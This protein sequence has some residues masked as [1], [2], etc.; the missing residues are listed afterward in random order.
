M[1]Q[2]VITKAILPK[3]DICLTTGGTV[4]YDSPPKPGTG[5]SWGNYCNSCISYYGVRNSPITTK[6]VKLKK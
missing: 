2:K 4:R 3:C 5:G 6:F 1:G